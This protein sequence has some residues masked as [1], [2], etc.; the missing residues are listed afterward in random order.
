[1][2]PSEY[3]GLKVGQDAILRELQDCRQETRI[4]LTDHEQR[5]RVIEKW[6]WQGA[7]I[8]T[9]LASAVAAGCA[10]IL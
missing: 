1:M 8:A 2:T 6:K 7:G 9:V 10:A 4:D 5:L 3:R